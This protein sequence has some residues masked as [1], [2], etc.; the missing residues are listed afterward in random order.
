MGRFKSLAITLAT[1]F[2]GLGLT[3]TAFSNRAEYS[4]G[5]FLFTLITGFLMLFGSAVFFAKLCIPAWNNKEK[6]LKDEVN[7]FIKADQKGDEDADEYDS[8]ITDF[9]KSFQDFFRGDNSRINS[10]LQHTSTQLYWHILSLQKTRM[11]KLGVQMGLSVERRKYD[12][13][14][15]TK[16]SYFD[17][18]YVITEAKE[19]IQAE[20]TY[21][22]NN[23]TFVKKYNEVANY[24]ILNAKE[25]FENKTI[26]CPNCGNPASKEN[27]VDGC[28]YC[29]T[30]FCLEDLGTKVSN[31]AFRRDH[32]IEYAK[33][34]DRRKFYIRKAFTICSIPIFIISFI[35]ILFVSKGDADI[36]MRITG[37]FFG[38]AFMGGA[39]GYLG[40]VFFA[41]F[42][43]PF[44][45]LK[46]SVVYESKSFLK[47]ARSHEKENQQIIDALKQKDP[48]FSREFFYSNIQN[49][50]AAIHYADSNDMVSVFSE[51]ELGNLLKNYSS[52]VDMDVIDI[53][54]KSATFGPDFT[55]IVLQMT[56]SLTNLVAS[57]FVESKETV[58][59][60]LEKS[61]DCKTKTICEPS[62]FRC[63][64][65]GAPISLLTGG[66]CEYCGA[67]LNLKN[68]DWVIKEYR[69]V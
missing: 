7:E 3:S 47:K 53:D 60:V 68:F 8:L 55:N 48:L 54:M 51:L 67:T 4:V 69:T 38:A 14:S 39:L 64:G 22:F 15:I 45:Q 5:S 66:H 33:Y 10:S 18:K 2:I 59:L 19:R 6:S 42:I 26:I 44:I 56:L 30:K 65:C 52:T 9:R 50:L 23:I 16:D 63:K 41:F 24:N 34:K 13:V 29:D 31:F 40:S 11:K 1:F 35:S 20:R 49:K 25:N 32:E 58:Q 12:G 17:G 62:A 61:A 57:R 36:A 37:A 43:F 28:D 21:S 27:L 46:N